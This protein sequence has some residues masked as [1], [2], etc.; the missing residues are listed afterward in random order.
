VAIRDLYKNPARLE[1]KPGRFVSAPLRGDAEAQI[2]Q[3][4]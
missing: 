1:E 2:V 3:N 4:V